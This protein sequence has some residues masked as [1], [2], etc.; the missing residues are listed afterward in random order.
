MSAPQRQA[1][2][3]FEGIR[4]DPRRR[5]LSRLEGESIAVTAKVFDALLYLV[6]R[7]GE[8]VS[9]SALIEAL[10]PTTIV[11]ENSLNQT[12]WALRRALGDDGNGQRLIV[13]L[14]GRGY[15]FVADVRTVFDDP[16]REQTAAEPLPAADP[17]G[18]WRRLLP[19]ALASGAAAVALGAVIWHFAHSDQHRAAPAKSVAVL[20][21]EDSS[22]DEQNDFALGVH[23]ELVEQLAK[24]NFEVKTRAAVM[25]Y[26][27]SRRPIAEIAR[28]LDVRAIVECSVRHADGRVRVTVALTEAGTGTTLWQE[29]YDRDFA[30]IFA[31]Q[32]DVAL[33]VA[34]ALE[35][36]LSPHQMAVLEEI[37][38]RSARAIEFYYSARRYEDLGVINWPTAAAQ[39]R[40]AVEEDPKFA[41]AFAQ[42]ALLDTSMYGTVAGPPILEQAHAAAEEALKL[43]A[44]LT[45]G[46]VAMIGHG[47][48][49]GT[50]TAQEAL[51]ELDALEPQAEMIPE[52]YSIRRRVRQSLGQFEGALTD[53]QQTVALGPPR[54]VPLLLY[55]AYS[56]MLLGRYAEAER[57][58][59]HVADIAPDD[60]GMLIHKGELPMQRD[61]DTRALRAL[62]EAVLTGRLPPAGAVWV[63]A[64]MDGDY[65]SAL[66][67]IA[68][69]PD[70][71][72]TQLARGI[73]QQSAG[74]TELARPLLEAGRDA[75]AGLVQ[76]EPARPGL[77]LA[78]ATTMGYLNEK[79]EAVRLTREAIANLPTLPPGDT[80]LMRLDAAYAYASAGAADLAVGELESYLAHPGEWSIEGIQRMPYLDP[81]RED[82]A[83][84][85][86]VS[87][88]ARH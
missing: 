83:F 38:S 49:V 43:D 16:P 78:Y 35:T 1:V 9:R 62:Q 45:E 51:D 21:C 68:K 27:E 25:P 67:I 13:T 48:L 39:Y 50:K 30:D 60:P 5:S 11:E 47:F 36:K 15:Q 75:L 74:R 40:R 69:G 2:Y 19:T 20:P 24:A 8:P 58:F 84:K 66:R 41:R 12:I 56:Y 79:D 7:A 57:I 44:N 22:A 3:E 31:I 72:N 55:E 46:R 17:T 82:P 86:L 64:W 34:K 76:A 87:K 14:P 26:V 54:A 6:E 70:N 59:E 23:E 73:V 65:D 37:P 88:Y 18:R 85:K 63:A 10:W 81:I 71:W 33:N 42:L 29:S 80:M 4:L 32:S 28:E 77:R 61:G 52:F 53:A